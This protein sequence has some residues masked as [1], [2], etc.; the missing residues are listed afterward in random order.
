MMGMVLGG[1]GYGMTAGV[2]V[3]LLLFGTAAR[4]MWW[5]FAAPRTAPQ[6]SSWKKVAVWV[7]LQLRRMPR[8]RSS[9]NILFEQPASHFM[10]KATLNGAAA[11]QER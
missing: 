5:P 11:Q 1:I 2:L 6:P 9:S 8:N 3:P 10:P 7:W 4:L